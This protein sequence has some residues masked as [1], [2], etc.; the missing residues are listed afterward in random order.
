MLEDQN[1]STFI[2]TAEKL[3]YEIGNFLCLLLVNFAPLGLGRVEKIGIPLQR[4]VQI[5]MKGNA[6]NGIIPLPEDTDSPGGFPFA[7]NSDS[8]SLFYDSQ[9]GASHGRTGSDHSG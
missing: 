2:Q 6:C 7:S 3:L 1:A 8:I 4:G 5:C 9:S